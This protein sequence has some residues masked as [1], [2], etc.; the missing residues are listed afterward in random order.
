MRSEAKKNVLILAEVVV[1]LLRIQSGW[2]MPPPPLWRFNKT[3]VLIKSQKIGS[4]STIDF[5]SYPVLKQI[6]DL[7]TTNDDEIHCLSVKRA[8]PSVAL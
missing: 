3:A 1:A 5:K 2:T 4:F 7:Q 8:Y 6:Y